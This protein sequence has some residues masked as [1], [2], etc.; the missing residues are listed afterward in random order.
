MTCQLHKLSVRIRGNGANAPVDV[1]ILN[2]AD[3]GLLLV[4]TFAYESE[5]I[6]FATKTRDGL[7]AAGLNVGPGVWWENWDTSQSA[8]QTQREE[9]IEGRFGGRTEPRLEA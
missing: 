8:T 7:K 3:E 2:R 4:G 9:A 6:E 1:L 5:A